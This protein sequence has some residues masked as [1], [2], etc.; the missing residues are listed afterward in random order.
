MAKLMEHDTGSNEIVIA[1]S[2]L[3]ASHAAPS[4]AHRPHQERKKE[5]QTKSAENLAKGISNSDI[6]EL[7]HALISFPFQDLN[8]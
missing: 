8:L 4:L 5:H 2:E 6:E 1:V 7:S 3:A